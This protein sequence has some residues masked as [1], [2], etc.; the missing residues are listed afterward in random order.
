MKAI[1]G[2]LLNLL[3]MLAVVLPMFLL[4]MWLVGLARGGADRAAPLAD[5]PQAF[6]FAYVLLIPPAL[7]G[8]FLQ[9]LGMLVAGRKVQGANLRRW[10]VWTSL[11]ALVLAPVFG[12]APGF[13]ASPLI[14]LPALASLLVFGLVQRLPPAVQYVLGGAAT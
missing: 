8:A 3:L 14:V 9:Q 4:L 7:G 10:A 5:A 13:L 12:V 11:A 1:R 6:A 2:I